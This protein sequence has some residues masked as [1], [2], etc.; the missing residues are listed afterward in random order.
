MFTGDPAEWPLFISSYNNSTLMCGYSDAEN[1]MRL[2]R[3]L[4]G[5][6]KEAVNSFLLHPSSVPRI[7]NTLQTLFGRPEQMVNSLLGKIRAMPPPKPDRLDSM[8]SF[9]LA[10]QNFREFLRALG[11]ESHL[12]N[13]TLMQELV[14]KLPANIKLNWAL[15]IGQQQ[16]ADL[17]KKKVN[18]KIKLTWIPI[19]LH[20][21]SVR[22][23]T[24]E[25]SRRPEQLNIA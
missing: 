17:G 19:Q 20:G 7:L 10:V 11:L 12:S 23:N 5:S 2:Q 16:K 21:R 6:A 15:Y 24:N 8:V 1:L 9:G 4:K 25:V 14:E 13:P 18:R 3:C 22:R